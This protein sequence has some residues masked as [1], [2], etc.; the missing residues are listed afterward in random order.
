MREMTL[1]IQSAGDS[2]TTFSVKSPVQ[3]VVVEF[4]DHQP[5]IQ[6]YVR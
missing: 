4:S 2:L 6:R 5:E 3:G 1:G